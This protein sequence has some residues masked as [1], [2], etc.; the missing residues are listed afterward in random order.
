MFRYSLSLK[1]LLSIISIYLHVLSRTCYFRIFDNLG[2]CYIRVLSRTCY[3]RVSYASYPILRDW[4]KEI[5]NISPLYYHAHPPYS[6]LIILI[7]LTL[8][9][10]SINEL[11]G[12]NLGHL[13]PENGICVKNWATEQGGGPNLGQPTSQI[14]ANTWHAQVGSG[15]H[16]HKLRLL[17]HCSVL[18][19]C[20]LRFESGN[21]LWWGQFSPKSPSRINR[22]SVIREMYT[23]LGW[24]GRMC[25]RVV[26]ARF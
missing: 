22:K 26:P 2:Y 5:E 6:T 16:S 8:W 1:R 13:V 3:I 15:S 24:W 12:L 14:W 17:S 4:V 19:P 21:G 10:E 11:T 9:K 25:G 23:E 20:M 18:N 7:L